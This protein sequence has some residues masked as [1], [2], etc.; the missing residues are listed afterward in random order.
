M[1]QEQKF[2][3][4]VKMSLFIFVLSVISC[5]HVY[6]GVGLQSLQHDLV[7][8]LVFEIAVIQQTRTR[9]RTFE[10]SWTPT[11]LCTGGLRLPPLR[12]SHAHIWSIFGPIMLNH[13]KM[14]KTK[15]LAAKSQNLPGEIQNLAAN[16]LKA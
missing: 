9:D 13:L 3:N 7:M 6:H 8:K 10:M 2:R 5:H 1:Y 4:T 11:D 15:N 14:L 12:C 16:F